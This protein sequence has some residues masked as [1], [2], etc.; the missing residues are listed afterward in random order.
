MAYKYGI[1]DGFKFNTITLF[2]DLGQEC[3]LVFHLLFRKIT[4]NIS[5]FHNGITYTIYSW[6]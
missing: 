2:H 5:L 1:L 3:F 6:K 4:K